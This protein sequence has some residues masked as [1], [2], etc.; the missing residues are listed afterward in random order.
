MCLKVR[1]GEPCS[2]SHGVV[3][4]SRRWGISRLQGFCLATA[5]S[6]HLRRWLLVGVA[7]MQWWCIGTLQAFGFDEVVSRAEA[8]AAADYSPPERIPRFLRELSYDAYQGIRFDEQQSLWRDSESRFQVMAFPAGLF[9]V[10][11]V[12]LNIVDA[13]GVQPWPFRR[14]QYRFDDPELER[15]V[16]PD[17]GH[18][19]FKLTYPLSG[20]AGEQN[21]F[22]VFAGASYFRGVGREQAWGL[23]ARGIAIDTG[24]PTGE[25]FPSF[26]EFWLVRPAPQDKS[27]RLY[28]L[29]EGPSLTGAYRFDVTPGET[30]QV[31][32]EAQ[33]FYRKSIR[34]PGLAPLTSMFFYGENTGRPDGEWRPEVH[35]SD[36]L[37]IQDAATGEHLWRPLLN[38]RRLE[39]DSFAVER[40]G[41]FGLL[42]RDSRFANYQDLGA[43][44]EQRPSA[45]VEP[46]GD[47]G[48]GRIVLTQLPT[49][50]ETNDNIVAFWTPLLP[51]KEQTSQHLAY[52]LLIGTA[53]S[54]QTDIGR[55][56][57]TFVGDGGI[58]GGGNV[59][60][61]VRFVVHF[62]GPALSA[63]PVGDE[64]DAVT[65]R[66]TALDGSEVLEHFVEYSPPTQSWRLSV[67]ARS[68]SRD[69][70]L[71]LRAYLVQG[72]H[73]LTETWTYRLPAENDIQVTG[74]RR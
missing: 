21:Q 36:G 38:P 15:R 28:A 14:S 39:M 27:L 8:L 73:A 48:P 20:R 32:V 68:A 33:L 71:S 61:A 55:V 11:S 57:D 18:A 7:C 3:N 26:T 31:E 9:Y 42:Q 50:D 6:A 46:L 74:R 13:Q 23:S 54:L 56:E 30:T 37:L 59:P 10:H 41:G 51:V 65:A 5:G 12:R 45:W 1:L 67:L 35:D 64:A 66:V 52:R 40:L 72:G 22:L 2:P 47:W 34:L 44:Y 16:P 53:A 62:S 19:G 49:P 58:L 43:R 69:Q 4:R 63:L 25:E 17:L 29:L 24:L 70:A 60:G